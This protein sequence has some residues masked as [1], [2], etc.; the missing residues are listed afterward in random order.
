MKYASIITAALLSI[1][2]ALA[3]PAPNSQMGWSDSKPTEGPSVEVDGKFMVPYTST[4]PGTSVKFKMIPIPGGEFVMGSP[5][6]E[7]GHKPEEGPQRTVKVDPM[8]VSE[9]E[10]TW[11]EYKTFMGTYT[12]FKQLKSSGIRKIDAD[13]R[14]DAI[15]VPT[16][17]YEPSHT[18]EYGDD[19]AQPAVTM[20]QYSAKQ[21]TKWLS[22]LTGIQYRIPAAAEWEYAARA[23]STTAYSFGDNAADLEKHAAFADNAPDGAAKINSFAPNA[24]GLYDMHGNVW[25]WVIDEVLV[26]GYPK[27]DGTITWVDSIA[28]P[29]TATGRC[30]RGGGFQ[31][32][33]VE[34]RSASQMASI[35]LDDQVGD[36]KDDDPNFP[37]SPWW[38]TSD[39]AR[40]VGMRIVRSATPLDE[41]LI[42]KFYNIDH[43]D[44]QLDVETRLDEGRGILG[45]AV[46]EL[47]EQ[48]KAV[49]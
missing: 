16:P 37:H 30:V 15:T 44:I 42:N 26:D 32:D 6:S 31:S 14:V 49:E 3:D 27:T 48:L 41:E 47:A 13:N 7:E 46:P 38:F 10:L 28:W 34:C 12:I 4:I 39:P 35:D 45:L 43:E 21:Y 25:E 24:F 40:S 2:T 8:W 33:A 9:S 18:Y 17:L 1:Q 20:T 23:G 36:W 19:P 11:A 22:G 5:D 29:T